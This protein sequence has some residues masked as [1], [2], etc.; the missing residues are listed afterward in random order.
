[1]AKFARQPYLK[2]G[3]EYHYIKGSEVIS[4]EQGFEILFPDNALG[5]NSL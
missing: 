4:P 5:L 1:M 2:T 3:K